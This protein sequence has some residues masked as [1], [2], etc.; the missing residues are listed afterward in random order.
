M[1]KP[2]K[3]SAGHAFEHWLPIGLL[4]VAVRLQREELFRSYVARRAW[5]LVPIISIALIALLVLIFRIL[6]VLA[7]IV[8]P[9]AV[10]ARYGI[11]LLGAIIWLVIALWF[12]YVFFVWLEKRAM[13]KHVLR[14]KRSN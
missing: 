10:V 6:A 1:T 8:P 4:E 7:G 9:G 5:L 3:R 14:S 12:I 11:L 13:E 2:Q